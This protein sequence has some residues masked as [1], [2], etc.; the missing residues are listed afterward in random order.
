MQHIF[1]CIFSA[2][3]IA[4]V[5]STAIRLH[6]HGMSV[7]SVHQEKNMSVYMLSAKWKEL[8]MLVYVVQLKWE[9]GEKHGNARREAKM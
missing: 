9:W 7:H 1:V 8:K 3:W 4:I 5:T 2:Q 6:V